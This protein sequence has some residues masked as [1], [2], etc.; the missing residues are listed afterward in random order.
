MAPG[1][2]LAEEAVDRLRVAEFPLPDA[3]GFVTWGSRDEDRGECGGDCSEGRGGIP[4]SPVSLASLPSA[5][6]REAEN[7]MR[8]G[9]R[10]ELNRWF[11][12]RSLRR[13]VPSPARRSSSSPS[14]SSD[15]AHA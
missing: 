6:R 3:G 13:S 5:V 14:A 9:I 4:M 8:A 2:L 11:T 7:G 10:R 1:V 12:R 15:V